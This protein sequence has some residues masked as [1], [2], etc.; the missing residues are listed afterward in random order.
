MLFE[1]RKAYFCDIPGY[2]FLNMYS[3]WGYAI[4][5]MTIGNLQLISASYKLWIKFVFIY[6]LH[7]LQTAALKCGS[8]LMLLAKNVGK[9]F[10]SIIS[11]SLLNKYLCVLGRS[12]NK[13][14]V[15]SPIVTNN[16]TSQQTLVNHILWRS[17]F[18]LYRL[19]SAM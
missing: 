11:K 15:L 2:F 4:Y 13:E 1:L 12:S 19:C 9:L 8:L 10:I 5:S 18:L 6:L 16:L 7:F 3:M 17:V 14:M